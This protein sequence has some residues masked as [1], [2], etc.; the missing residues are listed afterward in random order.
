MK[1]LETIL[2]VLFPSYVVFLMYVSTL[3]S[4]CIEL[5]CIFT[6]IKKGLLH[7]SS[8]V[9]YRQ[10]IKL[11]GAN[12]NLDDAMCR[13]R[14]D[15]T[16]GVE[17]MQQPSNLACVWFGFQFDTVRVGVLVLTCRKVHAVK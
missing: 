7:R 4:L 15:R 17:D 2:H 1:H 9:C 5:H 10:Q 11:D 12:K 14:S 13:T 6:R 3:E 8:F 16:G